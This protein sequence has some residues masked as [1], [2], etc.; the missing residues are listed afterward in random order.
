ME[1]TLGLWFGFI[2]IVVGAVITFITELI[3]KTQ[4]RFDVSIEIRETLIKLNES[5]TS[6][7]SKVLKSDEDFLSNAYGAQIISLKDCHYELMN[8]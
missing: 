5:L 6:I 3:I 4:M 2:G 8:S 7:Q 1:N